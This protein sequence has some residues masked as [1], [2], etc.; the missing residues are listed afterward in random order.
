MSRAKRTIEIES[1]NALA[2]MPKACVV[3]GGSENLQVSEHVFSYK[4]PIGILGGLFA[5]ILSFGIVS[6]NL[7]YTLQHRL[8]LR[9]CEKCR[10]KE[11]RSGRDGIILTI[12]FFLAGFVLVIAGL[13]ADEWAHQSRTPTAAYLLGLPV[14]GHLF[15]NAL[16]ILFCVM[17]VLF[18]LGLC[19]RWLIDYLRKP[20]ASISRKRVL[21]K[22]PN[23]GIVT[24]KF[25]KPET[26]LDIG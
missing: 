7:S 22:I 1:E 23:N 3:C 20:K 14:V 8:P 16:P 12:L 17:F 9:F 11:K 4:T 19:G 26:K 6:V 25:I 18:V 15:H 5:G 10:L 13:A 24:V 2:Q 21:I